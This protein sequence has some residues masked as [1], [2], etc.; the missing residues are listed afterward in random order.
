MRFFL[1][2]CA[3]YP[4]TL[5]ADYSTHPRAPELLQKLRADYGFTAV[6]LESVKAALRQAESLPQL[7]EAEQKAKEKT[8][9]WD[10]YRRIHIHE[11]NL[12][13]GARFLSEYRVWLAR[14]EAEFGVPPTVI[15]AILGVETKYGAYTGSH[16]VLDA[17]TTQGFDHPTRSVFFFAELAEFFALCRELGVAPIQV[18]GSYAGA[19]GVTQFMPS[20]YR[21]LA[22]DFDNN[23]ARNLWQM[24]DAIGS[25]GNYLAN[26]VP[27]R[28]WQRSVPLVVPA[29]LDRRP[30]NDWPLNTRTPTHRVGD[31]LRVDVRP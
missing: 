14:A 11:S 19:V 18:R 24:P 21:R 27:A 7:I 23:R 15:A 22:V 6:E 20:N 29:V 10:A 16:R 3:L 26:A 17:L 28:R 9:T 4:A 31:F 25:I 13:S 30:D 2:A 12:R 5:L 8:L 1:L